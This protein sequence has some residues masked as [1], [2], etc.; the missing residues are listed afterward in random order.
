MQRED[1]DY[2]M[3]EGILKL[4]F[5]GMSNAGKSKA[6]KALAREKGFEHVEVDRAIAEELDLEGMND[7]SE[8]LGLPDTD[9]YA[10]RAQRYLQLEEKH[11]T[12]PRLPMGNLV[13]DTTGSV[14]HLP[15]RALRKLVRDHFVVHLD[16]GEERLEKMIE[17]YFAQPK[18]VIWG[19]FFSRSA[20][21]ETSAALA[22][23]YP[24]LLMERLQRF[25]SI[26]DISFDPFAFDISDADAVLFA[27]RAAL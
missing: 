3:R 22:R 18:P 14:V 19:E 21:E 4:A 23:S 15:E 9:L 16:V 25:R 11:T 1:L 6:G 7:L 17:R 5:V 26:S 2:A 10:E 20:G 27:I 8:W 13:L 12:M 24:R